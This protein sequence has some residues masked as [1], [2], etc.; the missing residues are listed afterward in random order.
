MRFVSETQLIEP[1][2]N[3]H[4][5]DN[6]LARLVQ[7]DP[8][9]YEEFQQVYRELLRKRCLE[10]GLAP[11]AA[12][13]EAERCL[14]TLGAMIPSCAGEIPR[15]GFEPWLM[16]QTRSLVVR[17]W[18][19]HPPK[20]RNA[21]APAMPPLVAWTVTAHLDSGRLPY[22]QAAL[23]LA[24]PLDWLRTQH[25]RMLAGIERVFRQADRATDSPQATTL[26]AAL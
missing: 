22:R 17:Y 7:L 9:A 13:I 4:D 24:V 26:A 3:T 10:F 12:E 16:T 19:E 21:A 23:A 1:P 6:L 5:S 25:R 18:R 8:I 2:M 11:M 14:F 20:A 15:G